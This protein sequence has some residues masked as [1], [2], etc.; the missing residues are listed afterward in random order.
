[1]V[2]QHHLEGTQDHDLDLALCRSSNTLGAGVQN[3]SGSVLVDDLLEVLQGMRLIF[4]EW[5][6]VKLS[7][8]DIPVNVVHYWPYFESV[9]GTH[10]TQWFILIWWNVY[11]R[12][13][14]A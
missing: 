6:L 4:N 7:K 3:N 5:V 14:R 10:F 13:S 9:K 8:I 1:M 2:R 12:F 11:L